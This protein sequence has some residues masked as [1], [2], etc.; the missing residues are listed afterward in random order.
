MFNNTA[1]PSPWLVLSRQREERQGIFE[2]TSSMT[3]MAFL[4][5]SSCSSRDSLSDSRSLAYAATLL[6]SAPC[7]QMRCQTE[8]IHSGP[9]MQHPYPR[10]S[11]ISAAAS[12]AG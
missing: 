7:M 4:L 3:G 11:T 8:K 9:H 12:C 2:C 5:S 10:N 6:V 1:A